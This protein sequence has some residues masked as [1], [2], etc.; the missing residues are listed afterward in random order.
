MGVG[1]ASLIEPMLEKV[2]MLKYGGDLLQLACVQGKRDILELL[3]RK[4]ADILNP[5]ERV[6]GDEVYRRSPFVLQAAQSGDVDTLEA[7]L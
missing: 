4:G 5:P 6:Q 3:V 2:D 7:V 1:N